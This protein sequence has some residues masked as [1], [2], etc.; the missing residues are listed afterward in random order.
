VLGGGILKKTWLKTLILRLLA[1]LAGVVAGGLVLFLLIATR[2][3][4]KKKPPGDFRPSVKVLVATPEDYDVTVTGFGFVRPARVLEVIAE[5]DGQ[6]V[7]QGEGVE[8]GR[9]LEEDA[10]LFIIDGTKIKA[11]IEKLDA[12]FAAIDAQV[13]EASELHKTNLALV[14]IEKETYELAKREHERQLELRRKGISSESDV[15][16]AL[17]R[18]NERTLALRQRESAIALYTKTIARL[19]ANRRSIRA[20]KKFQEILL[21]KATLRA[22]Y[23]CRIEKVFVNQY[24]YVKTGTVLVRIRPQSAPAEVSVSLER[25]MLSALYDF[26]NLERGVPPWRQVELAAEVVWEGPNGMQKLLGHVSRIGAQVDPNARTIEVIVELPNPHTLRKE[27]APRGLLS[28]TF[29]RVDIRGRRF[30]NV[31]VI[32]EKARISD[33]EI[34]VVRNGILSTV[35]V[36][37]LAVLRGKILVAPNEALPAGS[38]I[39]LTEVENAFDGMQVRV[40]GEAEK[41]GAP[42]R[43]MPK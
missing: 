19:E 24:Q 1:V 17:T 6:I 34:Y 3:A 26:N 39:V 4:S 20:A 13:A 32:P 14:K 38:L 8:D 16:L 36:E 37:P 31:I 9:V 18:L 33:K 12:Q 22:P 2:P 21:G 5:V 23:A 43:N 15:D 42:E 28:G 35:T 41:K 25:R 7:Q 30:K 27:N 10:L 29:V 40:G 11:E